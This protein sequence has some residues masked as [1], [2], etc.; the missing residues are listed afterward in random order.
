[1][2]AIL[3]VDG[4]DHYVVKDGIEFSETGGFKIDGSTLKES[5]ILTLV[6]EPE[7]KGFVRCSACNEIIPNTPQAIQKHKAAHVSYEGCYNC[8]Y[9]RHSV[10]TDNNN[11]TEYVCNNDGTF[12]RKIV[13]KVK[14]HC[15]AVYYKT[16]YIDTP[17]RKNSCI[18]KHCENAE[19][20]PLET[21]FDRYPN[22]FDSMITA[23][24][25][26]DFKDV[27]KRNGYTRLRLKCRGDI[28][29]W[30]NN[31]GII[32]SFEFKSRYDHYTVYYS[33]KYDR[34]FENNGGTYREFVRPYNLT[35][36]RLGYIKET[37]A[38]LYI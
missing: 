28:Y 38:K 11:Q 36:E 34:L 7:A 3:R 10:V 23:D 5:N 16:R 19:I 35:E 1:M 24:A 32:D 13:D 14:L 21:F 37:I 8:R 29:A 22:A 20:K 12:S 6:G 33:K 27:Y 4:N 15:G 30:V 26:K 2:K 31:K 25:L 18:Y 17:E 9:L